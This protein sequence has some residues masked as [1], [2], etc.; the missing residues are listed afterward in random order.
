MFGSATIKNHAHFAQ[1]KTND[2]SDR[3]LLKKLKRTLLTLQTS[4][5]IDL[6]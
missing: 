3:E 1:T 4:N 5:K 2:V 6:C